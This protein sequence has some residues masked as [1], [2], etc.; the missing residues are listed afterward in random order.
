MSRDQLLKEIKTAQAGAATAKKSVDEITETLAKM[1]DVK[2]AAHL[3]QAEIPN[4]RSRLAGLQADQATGKN[5]KQGDIDQ[6]TA[7]I[8]KAESEIEYHERTVT[9]LKSKLADAEVEHGNHEDRVLV[10]K[11][12]FIE[13]EAEYLH[14]LYMEQAKHLLSTFRKIRAL[15]AISKGIG[16]NTFATGDEHKVIAIPV[17]QFASSGQWPENYSGLGCR[18]LPAADMSNPAL[19]AQ[20]DEDAEKTRLVNLGI[21]F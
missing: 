13:S 7:D 6:L 17:F 20:A 9:G 18:W 16:G 4:H 19:Y 12:K 15:S 10:L 3:A 8:K 21:A 2:S 14:T 11:R 1:E 5:V